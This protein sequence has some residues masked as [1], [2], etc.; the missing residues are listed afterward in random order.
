MRRHLILFLSVCWITG[1][2]QGFVYQR[3]P[4]TAQDAPNLPVKI[5][6]VA[7]RDGTEDF[8]SRG[9]IFSGHV[10]NLARTDINGLSLNTGAAFSVSSLP[11]AHWSKSLAEEMAASGVF[12]SVRFV[13]DPSEATGE[14]IV[15][16]GALTKA[17]FT[18]IND[19]PDEFALHLTARRMPGD[20]VVWEGDA[21]K[22]GIRPRNLANGCLGYGGCVI[23][24]IHAYLNGVMEGIFADA[25]HGL[26]RALAPPPDAKPDIP[27]GDSPEEVIQRILGKQ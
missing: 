23:K 5:A 10:F 14:E 15:V 22:S 4:D 12:R 6:V 24:R 27:V 9:N 3:K 2:S 25:R 13:F 21:G 8:T 16:E 7:F 19:K 17:Y 26:A 11:P 1:C 18:T 20:T